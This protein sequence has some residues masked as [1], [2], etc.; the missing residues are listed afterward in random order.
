[1]RVKLAA[2]LALALG[3]APQAADAADLDLGPL[4]GSYGGLVPLVSWQG[5]YF[6]GHAGTSLSRLEANGAIG[7]PIAHHFRGTEELQVFRLGELLDPRLSSERDVTY[8]ALAGYNFQ[9]GEAVLGIEADFTI[10]RLVWSGRDEIG[11]RA[12][13]SDDWI[14][15]AL[16]GG[17]ADA[18]LTKWATLRA[19]AGYTIGAFLPFVTGGIAVGEY[20]VS[21]SADVRIDYI[22]NGDE[23][24]PPRQP[25]TPPPLT[26]SKS[27]YGFGLAGGAGLDVALTENVFLRGEWQYVFFPD[28]GG[29]ELSMNTV[30]G[31]AGVKF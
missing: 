7:E 14:G 2:T 24:R 18:E 25:S 3:G 6:A 4:R 13:L 31:A 16:L 1:M 5:G 21:S 23:P 30:R 11:R 26:V 8:G 20:E 19:R 29:A 15:E 17:T 9:I 22:D 28:L 27:G 12:P 10:G